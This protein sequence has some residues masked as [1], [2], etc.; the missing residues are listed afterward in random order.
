M[1]KVK[2]VFKLEVDLVFGIVG[3]GMKQI[4]VW[5]VETGLGPMEEEHP[6]KT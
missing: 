2:R 1:V 3:R 5:Q 4:A 6:H